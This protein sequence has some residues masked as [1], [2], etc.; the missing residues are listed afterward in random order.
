[1]KCTFEHKFTHIYSLVFLYVS[2]RSHPVI[3]VVRE[4]TVDPQYIDMKQR[5]CKGRD[6]VW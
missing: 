2:S 1:M 3:H 5:N 4:I 6:G